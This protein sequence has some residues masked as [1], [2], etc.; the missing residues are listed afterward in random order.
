MQEEL[1]FIDLGLDLERALSERCQA[2]WRRLIVH[3]DDVSDGQG[4]RMDCLMLCF[5]R[6][7][8]VMHELR[9]LGSSFGEG[10]SMSKDEGKIRWIVI[11]STRPSQRM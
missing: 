9:R 8:V 1:T 6:H 10:L 11:G 7:L 2:M 4:G 3:P 5:I